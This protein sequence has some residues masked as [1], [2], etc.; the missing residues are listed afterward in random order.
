[1]VNAG[2]AK[3]SGN[4][5]IRYRVKLKLNFKELLSKSWEAKERNLRR[6]GAIVRGIMRRLIRYRKNPRI[7]SPP[8]TPPFAHFKP[9]IKNTIQF[10]V[11]RNRMIVGPQIARDKPN[12][13]PVPGALEHGGRTLVKVQVGGPGPK[14][15]KKKKTTPSGK[16]IPPWLLKKIMAKKQQKRQFIRV[17]A[18]IRPRP[19]ANPALQI[20]A[21]SPQYAE[22]WRNCIK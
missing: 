10:A 21:N 15:K 2:A 13:S 19:F 20:F 22:I 16:P 9:G 17:P 18:D 12:I 11:S 8:G 4:I 1:M 6:A 7:A 3:T 14:K 5:S